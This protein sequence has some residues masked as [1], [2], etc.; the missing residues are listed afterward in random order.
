[1]VYELLISIV[2]SIITGI[3]TGLVITRYTKFQYAK[4][5]ALRNIR[6]ISWYTNEDG[7]L[8]FQRVI[9][10]YILTLITGELLQ[11]GHKNSVI[12]LASINQQIIKYMNIKN[13]NEMVEKFEGI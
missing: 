13:N 9:D 6:M 10:P 7:S 8:I 4:D 12:E 1:M 3:Y 5:E 2:L 11:S